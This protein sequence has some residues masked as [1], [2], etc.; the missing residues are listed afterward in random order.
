[1]VSN[2]PQPRP[3]DP[4]AGQSVGQPYGEPTGL[5]STGA[6][7]QQQ[8]QKRGTRVPAKLVFV[9]VILAAAIWFILVNT[10]DT[11]IK[12]WVPTVTAPIW[13][14]LLAT[15]VAGVLLGLA[16]PRLMRRRR[17]KAAARA[18]AR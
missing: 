14:V 5:T 17:R 11:K 2:S 7:Q 6:V 8:Q 9:V 10:Q 13:L 1:M 18:Q 12:L 16:M 4:T 3:T 15:F